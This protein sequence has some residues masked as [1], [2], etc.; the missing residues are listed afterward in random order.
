[1]S[2]L[3]EAL[4]AQISEERIVERI[5]D[6][7]KLKSYP[8]IPNQ[9]TETAK[10]IKAFF[11][12]HGIPCE[13][14]EVIDGR[15]N[16]IATYDTGKP[17]KTLMFNSHMD[18]VPP[19]GWERAFEPWVENG[20]LYGRGARDNK[21]PMACVMEAIVA[22]KE[23]GALEKGKIIV[24]GVID[25]EHRSYGTVDIVDSG[26][27]ADAAIVCEPTELEVHT[28]Q[29]G[30]EWMKF[31]FIG[32]AV[33][34]CRYREGINA[35]AK[36]VKF[37][38]ALEEDLIPRYHAMTHPLLQEA[39]INYG[40]I[41]GGTQLSTV[42][43]DCEVLVDTR[44]LPEQKY[45]DVLA[46]F[47]SVL[48]KLAAED[49][50]FKCEMSILD[51]SVMKEGYVHMPFETPRDHPLVTIAKEA[52][53]EATEQEAVLNFMTAWTDG[54]ILAG[55]MNIPTIVLGPGGGLSHAPNEHVPV[56]H[57]PKLALTYA[58]AAINF[59]HSE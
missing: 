23:T 10:Y 35:I 48:D 55:Y 7:V 50:E 42:A 46:D 45:E 1:M 3:K 30:L 29:R 21:G 8:G 34:G 22:L 43:G 19:Y 36:A 39:T 25:E 26:I 31:H 9:E 47:Q 41:Q 51:V 56:D 44:F 59:C 54:G 37:I 2:S 5:K 15:C 16:V 11:D 20:N 40:V 57:M 27:T 18:T 49:P 6:M 4:K 14:K 17:G 52:V 33:H 32:R 13:L 12:A 28:C 53:T 38:N 58:L 24:T